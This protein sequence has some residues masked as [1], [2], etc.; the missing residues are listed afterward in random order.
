MGDI[1]P[2]RDE[3][4]HVYIKKAKRTYAGEL[5]NMSGQTGRK[6]ASGNTSADTEG[7]N[8]ASRTRKKSTDS[9]TAAGYELFERL[10]ACLLYTSVAFRVESELLKKGLCVDTHFPY[11][12]CD[13]TGSDWLDDKV[14]YDKVTVINYNELVNI[15]S[16]KY[17]SETCKIS[18]KIPADGSAEIKN[19]KVYKIKRQIDNTHY[20]VHIKTNGVLEKAD[21]HRYRINK[22]CLLYTSL[23]QTG[24]QFLAV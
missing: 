6:A 15:S 1:S 17:N 7:S 16:E 8:A 21:K 14:H 3:N 24:Q 2:L 5:L 12:S 20:S 13:I 23:Y 19:K 4:T 18:D 9:L 10:R 22:A 11:A